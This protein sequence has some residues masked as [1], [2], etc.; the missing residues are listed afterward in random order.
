MGLQRLRGPRWLL[1]LVPTQRNHLLPS[2][3]QVEGESVHGG[4][5]RERRAMFCSIRKQRAWTYKW[6]LLVFVMKALTLARCGG[7]HTC[8][9]VHPVLSL[10]HTQLNGAPSRDGCRE[11]VSRL[12]C[13]SPPSCPSLGPIHLDHVL[14]KEADGSPI[15]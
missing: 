13:G 7:L 10:T 11:P 9:L 5:D 8:V 15:T 3:F 12:T 14:E 2:G 6:E 4:K 1:S